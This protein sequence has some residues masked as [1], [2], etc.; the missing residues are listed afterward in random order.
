[1]HEFSVASRGE[2][3]TDQVYRQLTT[4]ILEGRYSPGQRINIREL[5]AATGVSQTPVRE[6]LS[7]LISEGV[8]RAENR[9]IEVPL[10][11]RTA[12][13]EIFRLRLMLEGDLAEGAAAHLAG[14]KVR[15]IEK[16]QDNFEAAMGVK[17]YKQVLRY[18]FQ[19]H[20]AIYRAA[21]RPIETQIVERLW[22]L[23]GPT[24]NL[25]YPS[26]DTQRTGVP[27]HQAVLHAM[28]LAD[29]A[30]LR[31]AVEQDVIAA[32]DKIYSILAQRPEG[33]A[34]TPASAAALIAP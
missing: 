13:P 12:F 7:R 33:D 18:N 8:L 21:M 28:R 30:R 20:F 26:F 16:I 2:S 24:M 29:P 23:V 17:D 11:E 3:L 6:A 5:A 1:M 19:F 9:S 32:R 4:G 22:L 31:V 10:I 25:M 14:E 15:E 27:R 34:V